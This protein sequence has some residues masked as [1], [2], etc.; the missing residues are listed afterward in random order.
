MTAMAVAALVGLSMSPVRAEGLRGVVELF[1]SQGC[2]S[3]PPADRLLASLSTDREVLALS[4]PVDY[5][6]YLGWKDTLAAPAFTARQKNYSLARGDGQ[7]Y[8]PQ[9]IVDG[10]VHA[11]GSDSEQIQTAIDN[12]RPKGALSV[13]ITLSVG[14]GK[15]RIEVGRPS[16]DGGPT[17]GALWL[18]RVAKNRTVAVGRGE[19]AGKRLTY[20]NVVRGLKH[21]GDWNGTTTSYDFP[22]A[23]TVA[24]EGDSYVVLLQAGT[25]A[26]PGEILAAARGAGW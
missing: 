8:T 20:T 13:P 9:V 6:D 14:A 18:L 23:W 7:V 15:V 1:T 21:I 12:W 25:P 4:F 16:K 22:V 11:V 17:A 2:S 26:R 24:G 3:C 5:W 10:M 19:N